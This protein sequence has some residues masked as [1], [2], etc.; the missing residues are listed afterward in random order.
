M[1]TIE[2]EI[3][4][5]FVRPLTKIF[6]GGEA[7][8]GWDIRAKA[9][10]YNRSFHDQMWMIKF[11]HRMK[12]IYWRLLSGDYSESTDFS[13]VLYPVSLWMYAY[14]ELGKLVGEH[15]IM[16]LL[17]SAYCRAGG[18]YNFFYLLR[19]IM[20]Q[21]YRPYIKQWPE[22][23]I[24][25]EIEKLE[26]SGDSER[27]EM[28]CVLSAY[29][30]IEHTDLSEKHKDFLEEQLEQNWDYLTNVYSFMVRRIVGSH[31]KGFVQIINNVA[32]AQSFHPYVHIFRKAVL[33][34]KDELFVTPK[35]KEK[36]ARHMAKLEDILK[37]TLQREDLDELCNIIFGSDFEEM[38]KTRYMSYD[39]LDKQRREL[40]DSVGG[41]IF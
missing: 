33:M 38:M 40:Q 27:G 37:T 20:D 23:A 8:E 30:M 35:S 14:D 29:L 22:N 25:K 32:V 36:L 28:L 13:D 34:R 12:P 6:D 15:N 11:H 21:S 41:V 2:E 7:P 16:D 10:E 39:E 19:C 31:F 1:K 24:D 3:D 9:E 26:V 18:L 17:N 4:E 5:Y